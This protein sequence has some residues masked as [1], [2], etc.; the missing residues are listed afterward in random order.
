M[1]LRLLLV[2]IT[3]LSYVAIGV[4]WF[5]ANPTEVVRE[6][7]P[8]FFYTLA[9]KDIRTIQISTGDLST[10]WSLREDEN[11]WY[12]DERNN[13][14]ADLYRWGGITQLMGG[15]RTQ[16]VLAQ[17]IDDPTKYGLDTPSS[18]F[19]VT[20]RDDS[21]VRLALGDLTPDGG[22][23]YAR[24]V[25]FP[26]LVLVNSTWG[27]VLERLV[28]DPPLPEWYYQLEGQVREIIMFDENEVVRAYGY[29]RD[30]EV[31]KI[32][33]LPLQGDPCS[34]TQIANS[35]LLEAEIAHFGDPAINGAVELNLESD[36]DFVEFGT[37]VDSPYI[38]LRVENKT[39]TNVTEVSRLTMTIGKVSKDGKSRFA[40]ANETSDV[41]LVDLEWADRVLDLFFGDVLIDNG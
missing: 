6:P 11:R 27:A 32:C 29:N 39:A 28:N 16:R 41:I 22:N 18:E 21:V 19:A 26:Q 23:N 10:S 5:I 3:V 30:A 9:P 36:G 17:N 37:T 1:N 20:L 38:A 2:L 15:P 8:P 31:W 7:E 24:V 14:P 34:G 25:G 35:D 4:T 13:I 12:F 40:V 33:D